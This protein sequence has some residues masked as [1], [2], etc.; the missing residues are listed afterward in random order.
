MDDIVSMPSVDVTCTLTCAG[1]RRKEQNMVKQTIGFSWGS[2]GTSCSVWTGVR[3]S[4]VL[5]L[6]NI[7]VKRGDDAF[8]CM[9]GPLGELPKGDDGSYGTSISLERALDPA[10]DVILAYKQ[11]GAYLTP[12]HGFPLRVIIPGYIGGRMIKWIEEIS[13][14]RE[15]S[16]SHYH[17]FDNR[18]LPS[19]IDEETA[20]KENWWYKPDYIINDL[21]IN[22]AMFTPNHGDVV[23]F[24]PSGTCRFSGYA[25]GNGNKIIRCE[26]S[27]DGC[28]SWKLCEIT[29]REPPNAYGKHWAWV[30]WEIRVPME[31]LLEAKEI[32]C[33]AWDS[34]M[35]TQPNSFTWNLMGMMNNCVFKTR[36][37]QQPNSNGMFSFRF[38]HPTLAGPSP[39]GWMDSQQTASN[40]K[41]SQDASVH[42]PKSQTPKF[43]ME[44]V[45]KHDTK[46]SAWFVYHGKVYDATP[47]LT[48][49]PGGADSILLVAG[50][51]AT[52]EFDAIHSSKAKSML[53]KYYIGDLDTG[54][55]ESNPSPNGKPI[56]D[57]PVALDPKRKLE[58]PL[59]SRE[60]LSH[61]VLKLR[62]GLQSE[63]HAFGLPVGKHVFVYA[64]VNDETVMRAYTPTSSDHDL[65]F[66]ELVIK[67]YRANEHPKFPLGGKM[68]QYLDSL[69]LGDKIT[70]KGPVG[71]MWY[72]G[73]GKYVLHG[74]EAT[75][76][77]INLM[78]GGTGITPC[79][80]IIKSILR[81]KTDTTK[82]S[83][84][85][86]N[87]TPDDVLL[88]EELDLLAD[89]DDRFSCWYTVDKADDDWT[90]S[91]GFITKEMV[92]EHLLPF[93]ETGICCMCG[94]PPMVKFACIPALEYMG[95]KESQ[96]IQF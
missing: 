59:I 6:C 8:V 70:I 4:H 1:N 30:W 72:K 78:A 49:H 79:Y 42:L 12:D 71:H 26:L 37:H 40:A 57:T 10:Y 52:E 91:V 80:Q 65:G 54:V 88:R 64:K 84:L 96:M 21:N 39:G 73:H 17:F 5:D 47:F 85:Y 13:V 27:I 48:A 83:L 7:Q 35:N 55:P 87:Q 75:T 36:V 34:T 28:K 69:V 56:D 74:S 82:V 86:A 22:S 68:S 53:T 20:A 18:V 90:F 19:H 58:F 66:F 25:Y 43:S 89:S 15:E 76:D 2:S 50:T 32:A 16:Q 29:N 3:L 51:D 46:E 11:N 38:E 61:N 93:T 23:Q 24:V 92:S 95:Y 77:Q 94:P 45:E 81:D 14:T 31:E 33:R 44:E 63:N 9:R 60:L 41:E 67:V 62:F